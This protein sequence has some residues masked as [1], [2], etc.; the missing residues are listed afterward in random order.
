M[1]EKNQH[2]I[3]TLIGWIV[4]IVQ[5]VLSALVYILLV[6]ADLLP[7]KLMA[8][9]A[10]VLIVLILLFRLLMARKGKTIRFVIG[11][12]LSLLICVV[13]VV[14]SLY[15]SQLTDTLEVITE[16]AEETTCVGVY[17]LDTDSAQS[18]EDVVDDTFGIL[19][20]Q[21]RE[22]A[23]NAID[24]IDEETGTLISYLE[25]EDTGALADAL[26]DGECRA[27]ILNEGFV[28]IIAEAEGYEDFDTQVREIASYEWKT[29]VEIEK[30]EDETEA[31]ENNDV[32]IMYI[33]GIDT[34]GGVSATGRSDTNIL[35]VVNTETKQIL[36]I[37]TPRDYYIPLSISN[38]VKDK[39][40]HAGI[41]GVQVSMDTL[42]MLYDI[43]INYYFRINF[44]GFEQLIDA[45]GGITVESDYEFDVEPSYHFEQG[46]NYLSGIEALAFARERYSFSSGDRQRGKNQMAVIQGVIDALQSPSILRNFTG[47]MDSLEDCIDTSIPYSL[48]TGMVK[49][50]LSSGTSWNVVSY[51]V[52]GTGSR[53]TTYSMNRSLYVMIPDDDTVSYAQ[54]LIEAVC[55]GETVTIEE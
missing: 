37:S 26:L 19:E 7:T 32:F 1:R 48:L 34:S 36:L 5:I 16:T 9:A 11:L 50:Q 46:T 3:R 33:S 22:A 53:A 13:L 51:S 18:I 30:T 55:A 6:R 45:L 24:Q 21:E 15:L 40:T 44:S 31:A 27:I 8:V 4:S 2:K 10:V 28:D 38:G 52:D 43:D 20:N 54:E 39:L 14:G 42:E 47:L 29:V 41:Y 17:V 12:V 35:A 23:D 25:Y 49:D